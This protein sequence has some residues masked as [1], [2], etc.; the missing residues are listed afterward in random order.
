MQFV[1]PGLGLALVAL[2]LGH[3]GPSMPGAV[4]VAARA[5]TADPYTRPS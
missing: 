4:G 2:V 5:A 1:V 3:A